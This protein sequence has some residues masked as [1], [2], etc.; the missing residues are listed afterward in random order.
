[1]T[2]ET[3]RTAALRKLFELERKREHA[4][5]RKAREM[6]P[7]SERDSHRSVSNRIAVHES[8]A[9]EPS[10]GAL[11]KTEAPPAGGAREVIAEPKKR[12]M[13]TRSTP[14][15]PLLDAYWGSFGNAAV[16]D[17]AGQP[18][19][20][21]LVVIGDDD[22]VEVTNNE[23]YPWRCVCSLTLLSP[24]GTWLIGTGWL[25]SPRLVLTAGHCVYIQNPLYGVG[26]AQRIEVSPGRRADSQPFGSAVCTDY[27]SVTGWTERADRDFDYGAILLPA[28]NRFGDQLGW[29]GYTSRTDDEL[30]AATVNLAGYPGDKPSGTQWFH[31][32][33]ID[34]VG[35]KVM[36]YSIDTYGGQSGAPV[37]QLM[38]DG[39]RYGVGI[40]TNGVVSGNSATR[41]TTD[42]FNKIIEWIGHAP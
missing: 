1:M 6:P 3:E 16:R 15:G 35:D 39:G 21:P 18:G 8:V 31:S 23:F 30:E 38:Q 29:L 14:S 28:G 10:F 7:T 41:I 36:T 24:N 13:P 22:R 34:D 5:L 20:N 26:W 40:H 42:V 9:F 33:Q 25:V 37:W 19:L 4:E 11:G 17:M 12:A 2:T 27:R 32:R